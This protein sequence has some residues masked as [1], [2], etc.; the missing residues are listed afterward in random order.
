[1]KTVLITGGAGF[2]GSHTVDL[3]LKRGFKVRVI[4]NL[5]GGRNENLKQHQKNNKLDLEF[6]DIRHVRDNCSYFRDLDYVVH[7]AGIG[8]IVPSI[9]NPK[10]YISNNFNGT[11]NILEILRKNREIKKFVYAASS[12]C[13]G[14]SKTPTNENHPIDLQHPYALSKY[15]GEQVSLNY[16]NSYKIPVNSIRIFNAYGTR[17]KTS[18]AYGAVFGV[19]LKQILSKAPLTVVGDGKQSRD[20]VYVTDLA[21]AFYKAST[22]KHIKKI[23]NVGSSNPQSI[24]YLVKLLNYND[25]VYI[26]DRPGEPRQTFANINLIKKDLN[27]KPKVS[28]ENGVKKILSNIDYWKNAPLWTEKKINK[29]TKIWFANLK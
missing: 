13:Y 15:L 3:F 6:K 5:S 26:P 19:F 10:K 23:W 25:V 27:W 1:M 29:A 11:L 17:S 21:E 7:F 9:T 20:F 22:S 8:D 14:L 2:I 16:A 12:S 28:F 18:G 24:N 4:D